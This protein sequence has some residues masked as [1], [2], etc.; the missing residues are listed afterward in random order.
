MLT[1]YREMVLSL[2]NEELDMRLGGGIP[3]PNLMVIEGDHGSGKS[4]LAQQIVYGAVK[5]GLKVTYLTTES[6]VRE[7]VYHA[8]KVSLDVSDEFLKGLLRIYPVHMEGVRWA[9]KAAKKLLEILGN[10]MIKTKDE[11]DVFVV[12]SFSVLAVY[13]KESIVL[14][15][16]TRAR[17]MVSE[18]KLIILTIHPHVLSERIMI[19]LRAVCDSYFKLDF[20][21]VAGKLIKV[22]RVVKLKGAV[23]APDS[24]IAFDVDPAFGIK[25]VPLALAKA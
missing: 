25:V 23:E 6:G 5:E 19:R 17:T 24:T 12:D 11:Y 1:P 7:F 22:L 10:F 13:A 21:E 16:L 15:Y 8:K 14:D 4:I 20:A 2:G 3:I 9:S 18:G